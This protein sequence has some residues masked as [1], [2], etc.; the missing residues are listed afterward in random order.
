M[1]EHP[2]HLSPAFATALL[3]IMEEGAAVVN[4]EGFIIACNEQALQLLRLP[5]TTFIGKNI[6]DPMW[7]AMREDLTPIPQDL[8]PAAI[9]LA[10]GEPQIQRIVGIKNGEGEDIWLSASARMITVEN[11]EYALVNFI[12]VTK[13]VKERQSVQQM[14]HQLIVNDAQRAN[15]QKFAKAFNH[16]GIGIALV[17]TNGAFLDVNKALC[18]ITGFTKEELLKKTFQEI[19]H[20]DDLAK[21]LLFVEQMLARKLD[22]Y[23]MEKRYFHKNGHIVWILLTVSMVTDFNGKPSFF[24]SQIV[25]ITHTKLLFTDLQEKNYA[26]EQAG[27]EL[28]EKMIQLSE[29]SQIVAHNLRGVAG[30]IST[31]VSFLRDANSDEERNN[32]IAYLEQSSAALMDTLANLMKLLEVK[33]KNEHVVK[34]NCD[35]KEIVDKCCVQLQQEINKNRAT[36]DI[37]IQVPTIL[38]SKI[39]LESICYNLI[40]NALKYA[41]PGVPPVIKIAT[42][43]QQ[44]EIF[45]SVSD[46]GLGIDLEKHGQHIFKLNKVF[47]KGKNSNGWGLFIVKNQVEAMGGHISIE[48]QP[49]IGTT[50]TVQ[51]A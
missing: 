17:S 3:N 47:H 22:S 43:K 8:S 50:F 46:N 1:N 40:S 15:D 2:Y 32:F 16:S 51:F 26:L 33:L 49:G 4:K 18:G 30:N 29:F 7:R 38:F 6:Y 13:T 10:G 31:L 48:S 20:P 25:D 39:Y 19:T 36:I 42:Y 12:D 34:E 28:H 27:I 14:V 21:D 41:Q 37:D 45:L 5:A 35:V 9:V 24:I 11:E 23:Q 44:G